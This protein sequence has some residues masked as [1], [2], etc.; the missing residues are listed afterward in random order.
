MGGMLRLYC[1]FFIISLCAVTDLSAGA[2]PIGVKFCMAVRPYLR[3][4]FS[5]FGGIAPGMAEFLA[6]RGAICRDML[7]AE[8]VVLASSEDLLQI[9]LGLR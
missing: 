1:L 5:Y 4:V 7:L 8:A 9:L 6:S 3:Q 2:L